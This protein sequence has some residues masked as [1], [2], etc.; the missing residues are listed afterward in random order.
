MRYATFVSIAV[1]REAIDRFGLPLAGYFVRGDDVE[2]T[3]RVLK[4]EPG[5]LVADSHV[6]HWTAQPQ[7]PDASSDERF[8]YLARNSLWL[9]RGTS[10]APIDRFDYGRWFARAVL[11]YVLANRR[12]GRRLQRLARGVRDGLRGQVR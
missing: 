12:D 9:L 7:G 4:H 3:A 10:F 2:Y 8:Y 1:R 5:F 6:H 11:G